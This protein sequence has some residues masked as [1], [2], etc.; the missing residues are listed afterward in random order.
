MKL[1]K[2]T[3][4][5]NEEINTVGVTMSAAEARGLFALAGK[6]NG[7][8]KDKLGLGIGE[9][10]YDCLEIVFGCYGDGTISENNKIP[11]FELHE[12]NIGGKK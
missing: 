3:F 9:G 2:I 12:L 7:H 11:E 5:S 10:Y 1:D 4:D 6:L 8:A